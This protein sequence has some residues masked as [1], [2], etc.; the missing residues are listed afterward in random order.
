MSSGDRT[1]DDDTSRP[2]RTYAGTPDESWPTK[3]GGSVTC[4]SG[5]LGST[6]MSRLFPGLLQT[7][8]VLR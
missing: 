3:T 6:G 2:F 5:F 4:Q 1:R 7:L 8:G